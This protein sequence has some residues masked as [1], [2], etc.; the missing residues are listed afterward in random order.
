MNSL[1]LRVKKMGGWVARACRGSTLSQSA[2][3]KISVSICVICGLPAL[4]GLVALRLLC[5]FVSSC[6]SWGGGL[7]AFASLRLCVNDSVWEA[8]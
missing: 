5:V 2:S 1:R 8:A 3:E 4:G 6:F 7:C